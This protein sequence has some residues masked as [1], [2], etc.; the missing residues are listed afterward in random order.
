MRVVACWWR[1]SDRLGHILIWGSY[2]VL[3]D[4]NLQGC[5]TIGWISVKP[6]TLLP[7][8]LQPIGR[9]TP[10]ECNNW[11]TSLFM[12]LCGVGFPSAVLHYCDWRWRDSEWVLFVI[13]R[14]VW[15]STRNRW[16]STNLQT[17]ERDV[18][19]SQLYQVTESVEWPRVKL[20]DCQGSI[21][22]ML[23]IRSIIPSF[24][25]PSSIIHHPSSIIH[26]PSSIIR[27]PIGKET[28]TCFTT[29]L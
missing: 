21:K 18:A 11:M 12:L 22:C 2:C 16:V 29:V 5:S 9:T 20:F 28:C 10:D 26:H 19:P 3:S 17:L 24:H 7:C 4:L 25:H 6:T 15:N 14:N 8:S 1:W 13:V 27:H 23:T